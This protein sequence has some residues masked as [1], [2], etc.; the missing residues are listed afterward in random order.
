M[1]YYERACYLVKI[2]LCFN[3]LSRGIVTHFIKYVGSIDNTMNITH[4]IKNS[5]HKNTLEKYYLYLET[6]RENQINDKYTV[7][8]SYLFDTIIRNE[9]YRWQA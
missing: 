1:F 5:R 8:A 2:V 9:T 4:A 7:G 6:K 3:L